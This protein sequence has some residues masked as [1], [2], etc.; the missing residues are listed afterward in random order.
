M[1]DRGPEYASMS[2]VIVGTAPGRLLSR[3]TRELK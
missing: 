1:S 2:E 3:A